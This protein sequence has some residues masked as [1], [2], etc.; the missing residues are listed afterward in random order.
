MVRPKIS[1]G[2]SYAPQ[3]QYVPQQG[4]SSNN[5]NSRR[6]F[7]PTVLGGFA[8]LGSVLALATGGGNP[9]GAHHTPIPGPGVAAVA[10]T[11]HIST[12]VPGTGNNY[13]VQLARTPSIASTVES[14][15][16]GYGANKVQAPRN[17][18]GT[19]IPIPPRL[20]NLEL[21]A[22]AGTVDT[23]KFFDGR[24]DP[25]LDSS[26]AQLSFSRPGYIPGT[27]DSYGA[28]LL[29]RIGE[30]GFLG[31]HPSYTCTLGTLDPNGNY[32]TERGRIGS[33]Y[34]DS[35]LEGFVNRYVRNN[36]TSDVAGMVIEGCEDY[37]P[38]RV[39]TR[40]RTV[41]VPAAAPTRR[42]TGTPARAT[43]FEGCRGPGVRESGSRPI[44]G[45]RPNVGRGC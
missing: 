20:S 42:V 22:L 18:A 7:I 11:A 1:G 25:A 45:S 29:Q 27:S 9:A 21:E 6:V 44:P 39:I 12:A 32:V 38:P 4:S 14:T 3:Q 24:L 37:N 36:L 16:N 35:D 19:Q 17:A 10:P 26:G 2:Q 23:V 5:R 34:V 8:A 15:F 31:D 43:T 33:G 40:T 30:G 28:D 13:D 41:R